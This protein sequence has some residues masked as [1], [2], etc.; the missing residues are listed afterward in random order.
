MT[1]LDRA[2]KLA[3]PSARAA[4]E[5]DRTAARALALVESEIAGRPRITGA[6][7]GGSYPKGTWLPGR[8]DIDI[9]VR[10]D[11]S[12]PR[13]EF[14]DVS[15]EVGFA[16]LKGHGPYTRFSEHPYVEA[17]ME[18]TRINVIPCYEVEKGKWKSAADRSRFHTAF[19]K[20]NLT[21]TMRDEV[22][23]LKLFLKNNGVYGAEISR[24]GFS[25]YA[26]EVLVWNFGGFEGVVRGMAGIRRG[27]VIGTAGK[28]FDTPV[29]IMDPVDP[30]R[31]LAAAVSVESLGRLVLLCRGFEKKQSASYFVRRKLRTSEALLRNCITVSFRHEERSPD[32]IWGQ[33][34]RAASAVGQQLMMA[35]FTVARS[36]A[37]T[38][39]RSRACLF[40]LLESRSI[41]EYTVRE[42][43][44]FFGGDDAERFAASGRKALAVWVGGS[45]RVMSMERRAESDAQGFLRTLLGRGLD[46]SGVPRGIKPDV[47]RGFAVAAGGSRL[48]ESVKAELL[49]L[50]STD[51]AVFPSR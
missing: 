40:F 19:M 24:Q 27:Q 48:P 23:L 2:R 29:S 12:A 46:G 5:K 35:G 20:E 36:G 9:F 31:N 16:A 51:A 14:E 33:V 28:E 38:D 39:G 4:R 50:V 1:V 44:D 32:T 47:K 3:V 21:S 17:E 8:S 37:W 18:G 10:F 7:F 45:G 41:P 22:R 6:E 42:G 11:V 15:K 26:T 43:P 25:G 49:E 34:K 30:L 13:G